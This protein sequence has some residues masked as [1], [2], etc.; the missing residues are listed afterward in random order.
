MDSLYFL[1]KEKESIAFLVLFF[2]LFLYAS[3]VGG[4]FSEEK[5]DQ[6]A[7]VVLGTCK[8]SEHRPSCYDKEIPKLMDAGLSMEEAF[9]VTEYVQQK[10]ASYNYC[11][12]LGHTLSAK[13]TAKDPSKWQDIITRVPSGVCS[14]GGIHGAFQERFRKESLP[15]AEVFELEP[16]LTDICRARREWDPTR[17]E[18]ATCT[19]AVGHLAMYITNADIYKSME[20]CDRVSINEDGYDFRQICYDGAFMQIFQPLEPEDFALVEGKHPNKEKVSVYCSAFEAKQKESCWTE[21]WPLSIN[22]IKKPDGLTV[23]CSYLSPEGEGAVARC[24]EG[25]VYVLTPFFFAFDIEVI[26]DFCLGLQDERK[27]ECIASAAS[28]IIENDWGS[29]DTAIDLCKK[30]ETHSLGV[31]CFNKLILY[32]TYNFHPGSKEFFSLCE[33]LEEPWEKECLFSFKQ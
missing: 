12:V 28:R 13:E 29:I 32:S 22:E 3:F 20:L 31:A 30:A 19:H 27:G 2:V 25:A 16:I 23:F 14:N 17:L 24:F 11:H 33:S 6:H 7:E 4:G 26:I 8:N 1:K 18:Q 15:D 9:A 10:D 21:S 5:I